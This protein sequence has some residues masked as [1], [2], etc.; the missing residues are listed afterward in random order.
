M[1]SPSNTPAPERNPDSPSGNGQRDPAPGDVIIEGVNLNRD[2]HCHLCG[3]CCRGPG[4]VLLTR[5]DEV[6]IAEHLG[7]FLREFRQQYCQ[8]EWDGS[9]ILKDH[10]GS[11]ACI[12]LN[13]D[14]TCRIHAA[15]P[16][17]CARFPFDWRSDNFTT[18]C[19]GFLAAKVRL[20]TTK[21]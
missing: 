11:D 5:H 1:A 10:P 16:H 14:N 17:Q 8:Q 19:A 7:L 13:P 3:N 20:S 6:R 21:P 18:T 15:K 4:I 2:F 9:Y 12:F